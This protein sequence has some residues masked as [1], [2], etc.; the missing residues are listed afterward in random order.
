MSGANDLPKVRAELLDDGTVLRVILDRPKGNILTM[1]MLG[2]LSDVLGRHRN[3][4]ALRL[5]ILRGGGGH[6]SFGASVEEHRTEVAPAMLAAFHDLARRIADY[7]VAIAA[8]VEG[9]CLGGAFELA[10]CCT[11]V[12][13]T[14]NARL[15][16]PEIKLG[17]F[18]P[19]LAVL[20]PGRLGA[21]T[22]ERLM[23]TGDELDAETAVRLGFAIALPTEDPEGALLAWYRAK[24]RPRSAHALRTA[25]SVVRDGADTGRVLAERL[26]LLERRYVAEVLGS[27]D[28]PVGIEAFIERRAPRWCDS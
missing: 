21:P 7:P 10:L 25:L 26:D 3:D 8:L 11:F 28:G 24:L 23:L 12:F 22:T 1:A 13:C 16:C 2:E 5:V 14:P 17:V 15:A 19:V 20:G 6:F 18:P 27:H 4:R 9:K